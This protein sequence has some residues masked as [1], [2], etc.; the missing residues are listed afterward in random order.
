MCTLKKHLK[1]LEEQVSREN[2]SFFGNEYG[3]NRSNIMAGRYSPRITKIKKSI[4]DRIKKLNPKNE[5]DRAEIESAI[6]MIHQSPRLRYFADIELVLKSW[7][8]FV[9][10]Q[11]NN[12]GFI[13]KIKKIIKQ[14]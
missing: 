5:S 1:T 13:Q 2:E 4:D 7:L 10:T 12:T 3:I 9:E 14:F 6:S 8:S 11:E